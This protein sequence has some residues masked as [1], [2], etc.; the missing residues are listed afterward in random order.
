M[1][2]N[3]MT[4][5]VGRYDAEDITVLKGLEAVRRRPG[6]YVGG[7]DARALHHMVYEV[8]D[9]SIDEALGG[10]CKTIKVKLLKD[11][12]VSVEDDGRGIPTDMHPAD[13]T[14]RSA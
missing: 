7:T 13:W 4:E 5:Q 8:V 12:S 3:P 1:E 10:F 11:G 6:M 14:A 9:N 2:R